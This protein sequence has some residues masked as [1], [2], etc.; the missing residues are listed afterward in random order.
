MSQKNLVSNFTSADDEI[1]NF[2][3]NFGENWCVSNDGTEFIEQNLTFIGSKLVLR[4]LK[5][6]KTAE[7]KKIADIKKFLSSDPSVKK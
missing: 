2:L 5:G 7:Y 3:S 1:L 6:Y 4:N